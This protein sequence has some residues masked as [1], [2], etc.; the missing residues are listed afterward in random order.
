MTENLSI[1]EKNDCKQAF[2]IF[3]ENNDGVIPIEEFS[4][5]LKS[6]GCNLSDED[7][8]DIL[9]L[10]D[11]D[12]SNAIDYDEFELCFA[13]FFKKVNCND[14]LTDLFKLFDEDGDGEITCEEFQKVMESLGEKMSE[15]EVKI[16]MNKVDYDQNGK[17]NYPEFVKLMKDIFL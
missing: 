12:N 15:K 4:K 1:T 8:L 9:K 14:Q 2:D 16:I 17:L 7:F 11:K 5:V 13:K 6:M 3:D 10:I